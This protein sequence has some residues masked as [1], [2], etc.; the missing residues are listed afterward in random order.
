MNGVDPRATALLEEFLL[1]Q[2]AP[3]HICDLTHP[4]QLPYIQTP[5]QKEADKRLMERFGER[6]SV[7][8]IRLLLEGV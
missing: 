6:Y 1:A 5:I 8:D 2:L 7:D 4:S 3:K